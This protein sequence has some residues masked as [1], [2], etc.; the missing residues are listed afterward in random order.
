MED[1]VAVRRR[2][3]TDENGVVDPTP[4]SRSF[5]ITSSGPDVEMQRPVL[6]AHADRVTEIAGCASLRALRASARNRKAK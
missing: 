4:A 1:T 2:Q 6:G 5:S 3:A